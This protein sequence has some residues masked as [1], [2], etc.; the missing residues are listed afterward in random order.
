MQSNP[1][2][3]FLSGGIAF[4][5]GIDERVYAYRVMAYVDYGVYSLS[6]NGLCFTVRAD[7][8]RLL[9]GFEAEF[10]TFDQIDWGMIQHNLTASEDEG[11]N[12]DEEGLKDGDDFWD[13]WWDEGYDDAVIDEWEDYQNFL[14]WEEFCFLALQPTGL[15]EFN[16]NP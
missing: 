16:F 4:M 15:L 14:K 5:K 2:P 3:K 13:G 10:P 8:P 6:N 12:E 7:D 9:T 11:G 1:I